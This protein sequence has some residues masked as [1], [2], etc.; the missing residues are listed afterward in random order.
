MQILGRHYETHGPVAVTIVDGLI[1]SIEPAAAESTG[2]D[3]PWIAPGFVDIQV[4]GYAGDEFSSLELTPERVERILGRHDAFGVTRLCPT[5]T[6]ESFDVLAHGL[7]AIVDACEGS[8][9]VNRRVLGIHVEGPYISPHDGPRGAHP[10]AHCRPPDWDEFQRLQ[11]AAAGRIRLLTLS[12]EYEDSPQF[13]E[14]VVQAI[15]YS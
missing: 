2:A 1:A 11:Q 13:I 3:L 6:T 5:L 15:R 14:K 4:N 7:R 12:P 10:L 9:P 8:A